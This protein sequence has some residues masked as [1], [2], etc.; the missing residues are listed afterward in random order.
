MWEYNYTP[1]PDE[2][3]HYGVKGMKW[4]KR[5][6]KGFTAGAD[7]ART[8]N[9]IALERARRARSG[10]LKKST[11]KE[12]A[13]GTKR[14]V[15]TISYDNTSTKLSNRAQLAARK[16]MAK[17]Q[18]KTKVNRA[19]RKVNA[20]ARAGYALK[21]LDT[22]QAARKAANKKANKAVN[23]FKAAVKTQIKVS[24]QK[25]KNKAMAKKYRGTTQSK[26]NK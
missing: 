3:M 4:K 2:L 23:N 12:L 18:L 9:A 22:A 16:S 17:Q 8:A 11:M 6:A 1:D 24:K 25:K 15:K 19:K 10:P 20:E 26:S 13:T 21:A 14:H 7:K 5:I